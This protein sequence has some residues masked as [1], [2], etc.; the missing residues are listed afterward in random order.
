MN[1]NNSNYVI[2]YYLYVINK[3]CEEKYKIVFNNEQIT[4][5]V[6]FIVEND[7]TLNGD[8]L[9]KD[10]VFLKIVI[11]DHDGTYITVNEDVFSK[12]QYRQSIEALV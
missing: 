12:E 6:K 11:N 5:I 1:E 4:P 9:Y 2:L 8:G 3:Y 10:D 7:L